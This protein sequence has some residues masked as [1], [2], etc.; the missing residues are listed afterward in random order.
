MLVKESR[1]LLNRIL[2]AVDFFFFLMVPSFFFFSVLLVYSVFCR[3]FAN[4]LQ[5]CVLDAFKK[6]IVSSPVSLE[7]FREEG[8]WD[9]IFSENFF[10]FGPASEDISGEHCTYNQGFTGKLEINS[11]S[12]SIKRQTKISSIEILQMEVISFV[13]FAA[14]CNGSVH[15][16]VGFSFIILV[17]FKNVLCIM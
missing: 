3:V 10:Y 2:Q 17:F 16:L 5:H 4:S 13:E 8:L 9:L 12:R 1:I 7:V 14:T 6:V 15:N 11:P